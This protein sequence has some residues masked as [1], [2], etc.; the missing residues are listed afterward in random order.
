MARSP[1][2]KETLEVWE[3]EFLKLRR[4][5]HAVKEIA[6]SSGIQHLDG[7]FV[8]FKEMLSFSKTKRYK[9]GLTVSM[10]AGIENIVESVN[11]L[12]HIAVGVLE[13]GLHSKNEKI[14]IDVAKDI[15]DRV[16]AKKV[17]VKKK[18]NINVDSKD[19][20]RILEELKGIAV[21]K[22]SVNV[23]APIIDTSIAISKPKKDSPSQ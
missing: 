1:A 18:L 19:M 7:S 16:G 5:G 15:L 12:S 22:E 23:D 11:K 3:I 10:E 4:M 14:R 20:D 13:R 21:Y 9:T 6:K 17:E 2:P 8:S